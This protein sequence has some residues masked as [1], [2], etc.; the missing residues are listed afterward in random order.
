MSLLQISQATGGLSTQTFSYVEKIQSQ[1]L[2]Y[3]PKIV[4]ALLFYII[5]A[6]IIS[7]LASIIQSVLMK[8]HYDASLQTF[9]VSLIKVVLTILLL[10]SIAGILGVDTTAFSALIVG[11][12]VAIGS[13]LNGTLGNF[14]GGVM[15]LIF[16]PFK[17]GD[18][19]EAQ[20]ITGVV[21]EQGVFNTTV[22]TSENKTVFLPN[23]AL[24]TNTITN[25][26]A[27]GNLRVDLK[28]AIANDADL[29]KAKRV[30]LDTIN[31]QPKVLKTPAASVHVL[32]VANGMTTL[33][34]RPYAIQTDYW[35]V[36]FGCT[37]A[38]KKAFE[39]EGIAGPTPTRIIINK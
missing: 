32:E 34:L 12:G 14:A 27:H 4:G 19:I 3:L 15:M 25:Y 13:A 17:V 28:T 8:K 29:E 16:K 11:A 24:S 7:R 36:Y 20:G 10:I 2:N 23:G 18:L 5:G 26:T 6:W 39:K 38:V 22:L 37:E 30:A 21:T 9:L 35:E 33:A 31:S 1:A